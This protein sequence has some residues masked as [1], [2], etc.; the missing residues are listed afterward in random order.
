MIQLINDP[1]KEMLCV[2]QELYPGKEATLVFVVDL[3]EQEGVWSKMTWPGGALPKISIDIDIPYV[4]VITLIAH[5][6]A[7]IVAGNK[8]E[9]N[10]IWEEIFSDLIHNFNVRT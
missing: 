4:E 8:S 3:Y 7:H 2:C 10:V 1:V 6:F 5:E 9:H